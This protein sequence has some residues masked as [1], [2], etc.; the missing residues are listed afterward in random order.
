VAKAIAVVTHELGAVGADEL[1]A[2][3][4]G[5]AGGHPRLLGSERLDRAAVEDL[6]LDGAAF[7]D[8]T[9]GCVELVEA[10][11]EHGLQRGRYLDLIVVDGHCQHLGDEERIAARC[12][13][14]PVAKIR[15]NAMSDQRIRVPGG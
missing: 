14:D 2:H 1:A 10:C 8:S 12:V 11:C 15:G 6:S 13:G 4:C 5:E 7:Q 3:E 9:F